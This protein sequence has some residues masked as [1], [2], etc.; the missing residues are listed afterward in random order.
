MCC[1]IRCGSF[2]L[3]F[4]NFFWKLGYNHTTSTVRFQC[5]LLHSRVGGNFKLFPVLGRFLLYV[6]FAIMELKLWNFHL[7]N[8]MLQSRVSVQ[9][10]EFILVVYLP[11]K[12]TVYSGSFV[13]NAILV[14]LQYWRLHS[15]HCQLWFIYLCICLFRC[16]VFIILVSVAVCQWTENTGDSRL[17]FITVTAIQCCW[18]YIWA[19]SCIYALLSVG[20]NLVA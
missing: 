3:L 8:G 20:Y 15:F 16:C 19:F 7:R 13:R 6:N 5:S 4:F 12:V 10:R 14:K 9:V 11:I 1:W 2:F 18:N 17:L